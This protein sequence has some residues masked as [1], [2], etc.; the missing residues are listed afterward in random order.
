MTGLDKMIGQIQEEA[1][2]EAGSRL[3]AAR[4]EAEKI[5]AQ[6]EAECEALGQAYE[7][8]AEEDAAR[9]LERARSSADMKRRMI[10]LQAKQEVVAG[11]LEKAY[12]KLDGLEDG[13][14]FDLLRQLLHRYAQPMDGEIC[15]SERDL[16]RLPAGF[17]KEIGK[18]ASEHKGSLRLKTEAAPI[19]NGFLLIYGG[20]EENCTFRALFASQ[21]E[22][23][24][25]TAARQLFS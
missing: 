2:A 10:L 15:F 22:T 19:E 11:V 14:Y 21:K 8:Q 6:A 25:D 12:E 20:I 16:K 3:A 7:S 23:L 5:A 24:Q 9:Y 4:E 13:A 1:K 18:I 17:E